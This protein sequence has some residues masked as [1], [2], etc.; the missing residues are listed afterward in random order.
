[1]LSAAFARAMAARMSHGR[2]VELENS[3]HHVPIDNP[4]GLV[5]VMTPFL[6]EVAART[7]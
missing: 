5:S 4:S 6:D 3:N 2:M 7:A 1:V